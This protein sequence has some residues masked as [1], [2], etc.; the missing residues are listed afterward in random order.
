ML[1]LHRAHR[2]DQDRHRLRHCF[3][4]LD[5]QRAALAFTLG[6]PA[7]R[8]ALGRGSIALLPPVPRAVAPCRQ[9]NED[10]RHPESFHCVRTGYIVLS[11]AP[12]AKF[13]RA[14]AVNQS[15]KDWMRCTRAFA[16][17]T[18]AVMRSSS[19]PNPDW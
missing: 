13:S 9:A 12:I 4:R 1:R 7:L 17:S 11:L 2:L 19:E 16:S 10:H 5:G 14:T 6:L 8:F 15:R 3:C 18:W